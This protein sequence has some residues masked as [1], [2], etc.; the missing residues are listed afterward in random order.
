MRWGGPR[1]VPPN[2]SELITVQVVH[3]IVQA[4][5]ALL[6]G[7]ADAAQA[8]CARALELA[9]LHGQV[10]LE[11]DA[12]ITRCEVAVA[13]ARP[14][15]G[16]A[17]A[18]LA[19]LADQIGSPRLRAEARF[20]S[21]GVDAAELE[22]LAAL[23][24]LAPAAARRAQRLLGCATRVD[25]LDAVLVDRLR[26]GIEGPPAYQS[27]WGLDP[28]RKAVWLPGRWIDLAAAP[29]SQQILT[30][31]AAAGGSISKDDLVCRAWGESEYHPLRHDKRMQIAVHRLRKQI[32]DDPA[33]PRR[34]VTT[35]DGYAL[36]PGFRR[37][38]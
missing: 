9:R 27:G 16:E 5:A 3:A 4:E 23:G 24:D 34:L 25:S 11:G 18:A 32:E 22:E 12:L 37:R 15:L 10:L 19:K 21:A 30:V 29:L 38:K 8:A 33:A 6:A 17:A 36:G 26:A 31:V 35:P 7:Q 20:F 13:F 2:D 14:D 28:A 1:A